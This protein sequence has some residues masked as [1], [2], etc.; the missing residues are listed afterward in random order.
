MRTRNVTG[1]LKGTFMAALA[2]R[3]TSSPAH[4]AVASHP[5]DVIPDETDRS[6]DLEKRNVGFPVSPPARS[7]LTTRLLTAAVV[8]PLI[9]LLLFLGPVW[10]WTLFIFAA[11]GLSAHEF[12]GLTHPEDRVARGAGVL[13][14]LSS[15]AVI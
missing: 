8:A 12:F 7:N 5:D 10:G 9:L 1:R 14:T 15:G 4:D 3:I 13:F 2:G 11:T 6:V